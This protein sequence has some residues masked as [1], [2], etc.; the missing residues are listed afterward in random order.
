L[1]SVFDGGVDLPRSE[2]P[3]I[4]CQINKD[5]VAL[6]NGNQLRS[7]C[8]AVDPATRDRNDEAAPLPLG[9]YI[10]IGLAVV[11]GLALLAWAVG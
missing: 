7:T 5:I 3:K 9:K 2:Y 10:A 1:V 6:R 8:A 11:F 4:P